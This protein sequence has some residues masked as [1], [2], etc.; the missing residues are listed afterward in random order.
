LVVEG[1]FEVSGFSVSGLGSG[2]DW[3]AYIQSV[4]SAKE[5]ALQRTLG[6]KNTKL[7]GETNVFRNIQKMAEDLKAVMKGFAFQ[8]DFLT[9]VVSSTDTSVVTG[10]ANLAAG[11][12]SNKILVNQLATNENWQGS[13]S[14]VANS[15]TSAPGTLAITVRG[16]VTTLN[17]SAGTTLQQLSDQINAANLGVTSTVYD[18]GAGGA[19]PARLSITDNLSGK[20]NTD[21]T[22]GI[23][24]NLGFTSTLT[25]LATGAFS[26]VLEGK[27]SQVQ[28]N[29]GSTIYHDSNTFSDL[30]SGLT[31]NLVSTS[32]TQQTLTVSSSNDAGTT[33]IN[34]FISKYNALISELKRDVFYDVS[35][36]KAGK[37]Q[38]NPTAGNQQLRDLV[39]QLQSSI[40]GQVTTLPQSNAVRALSDLGITSIFTSAGN[41]DNGT[42]KL[43]GTTLS[44]KLTSSFDDVVDFFYGVQS[45][46]VSYDG[47]SQKVLKTL[48]GFLDPTQG[49]IPAAINSFNDQAKRI[50]DDVQVKL[51]R[52]QREEDSM[53]ARFA[54]LETQ[55]AQLNSRGDQL[56]SIFTA[57]GNSSSKSKSK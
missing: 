13:F 54:R 38:V 36:A 22:A 12:Q 27:D 17:V 2:I 48:D 42:L 52:I 40:L 55:L 53:K 43:D 33:K 10:V 50:Q 41:A 7:S 34:D 26:V 47:F 49:A 44:K 15:V 25:D 16:T 14:G 45:G 56:N 24:Y 32:V 6:K 20:S 28:V 29:G 5:S 18:T 51:D 21:Q 57:L 11:N 46:G 39:D 31:I 19:T 30:I 23:N 1:D 8:K 4:R 3:S 37:D 35:L 9:K